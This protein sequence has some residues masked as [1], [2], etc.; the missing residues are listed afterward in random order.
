MGT[1]AVVA[2]ML[3]AIELLAIPWHRDPAT[4]PFTETASAALHV[5]S[6]TFEFDSC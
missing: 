1:E 3:E 5:R 6:G 2:V 4:V